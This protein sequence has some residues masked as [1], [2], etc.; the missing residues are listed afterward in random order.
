MTTNTATSYRAALAAIL[1]QIESIATVHRCDQES[2]QQAADEIGSLQYAATVILRDW[3]Q[4]NREEE[5][6]ARQA[7]AATPEPDT[8]SIF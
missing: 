7:Q 1:T 8:D 5:E 6:L 2:Y 3:A 4:L